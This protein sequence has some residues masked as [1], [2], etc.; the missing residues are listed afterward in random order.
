MSASQDNLLNQEEIEAQ[1]EALLDQSVQ[2]EE[3]LADVI[4]ESERMLDSPKFGCE[5]TDLF[6]DDGVTDSQLLRAAEAPSQDEVPE[7]P[8]Q[9]PEVE[10]I[11]VIPPSQ[12]MEGIELQQSAPLR[13]GQDIIRQ[14]DLD[15][16]SPS[17]EEIPLGQGDSREMEFGPHRPEPSEQDVQDFIQEMRQ[18]AT[19]LDT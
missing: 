15:N 18:R 13:D 7:G 16:S 9:S 19:L 1:E 12:P 3:D 10:V 6:Q 8:V 14:G 11:K 17:V 2:S 4:V 5:N